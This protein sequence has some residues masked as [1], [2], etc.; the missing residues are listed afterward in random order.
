M[1]TTFSCKSSENKVNTCDNCGCP[2]QIESVYTLRKGEKRTVSYSNCGGCFW[3]IGFD[4]YA[5]ADGI[6][7]QGPPPKEW[8]FVVTVKNTETGEKLRITE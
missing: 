1:I 7:H 5:D 8:G 6:V 3:F 2:A 4:E